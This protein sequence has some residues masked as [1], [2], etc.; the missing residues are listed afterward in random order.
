[1]SNKLKQLWHRT[2]RACVFSTTITVLFIIGM[3]IVGQYKGAKYA[4]A[5]AMV[6]LYFVHLLVG[7]GAGFTV[8][9]LWY[10]RGNPLIRRMAIY[11][12]SAPIMA[13]TSI[14]LIFMA[15]EVQ[16][17]WKFSIVWFAGTLLADL[18]RLPFVFY[19]LRGD[20][21]QASTVPQRVTRPP[22]APDMNA[23]S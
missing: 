9:R 22:A 3:I 1:M 21:P 17:T 16:L 10:Y 23:P 11:L 20:D 18:T 19:M 4:G 7:A 8:L 2:P 12:H 6:V 5:L 14:V 15:R 13:V